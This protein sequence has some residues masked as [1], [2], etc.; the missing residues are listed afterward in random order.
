MEWRPCSVKNREQ[1]VHPLPR[2][3]TLGCGTAVPEDPFPMLVQLLPE[4]PSG[5]QEQSARILMGEGEVGNVR[6]ADTGLVP[7]SLP[8]AQVFSAEPGEA[9]R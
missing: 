6:L 7:Q 8:G 2:L 1:A 4:F 9:T 3:G 5:V